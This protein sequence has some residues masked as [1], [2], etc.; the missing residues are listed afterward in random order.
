M[1][2]LQQLPL[3]LAALLTTSFLAAADPSLEK[4]FAYRRMCDASAAVA[5]SQDTFIV[6]SDEDNILRTYRQGMP[7]PVATADVTQFLKLDD[8]QAEADI[9]GAAWLG[10]RIYW[11]TSHGRN[12]KG[13]KRPDRQRLFA[14][15]A[16]IAGGSVVVTPVDEPYTKLLHDLTTDSLLAGLKLDDAEKLA[17]EEAGGLNVEGLSSTPDGDLLIGFRNPIPAGK[18]VLVPL[19]NPHK[20]LNGH[21]AKFGDPVLLDLGN[22]GVRSLEYLPEQRT[23]LIVAGPFNDQGTFAVYQWSGSATDAPIQIQGLQFGDLHPESLFVQDNATRTLQI[24]SDDGGRTTGNS[25]TECKSLPADMQ[26]F[27]TIQ[28]RK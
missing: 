15:T 28:L 26:S 27:R 24:L 7:E 17:P 25:P 9:E 19:K 6:A 1:R 18:A 4:P 21:A 12:S 16:N 22:R 3:C 14:T 2:R 10:D 20:I 11:I 13:K 5:L 8:P 23:F